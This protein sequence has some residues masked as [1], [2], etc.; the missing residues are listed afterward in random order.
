MSYLHV[1]LPTCH[2][3]CTK[4][5]FFSVTI[6]TG[7][8]FF[9]GFG[10]T[11]Y[12]M[13]SVMTYVHVC[14]GILMVWNCKLHE[15]NTQNSSCDSTD[16]QW[17]IVTAYGTRCVIKVKVSLKH[18]GLKNVWGTLFVPPYALKLSQLSSA[19]HFMSKSCSIIVW[20]RDAPWSSKLIKKDWLSHIC[21]RLGKFNKTL[22][23]LC[24]WERENGQC[25]QDCSCVHC[26]LL[27]YLR[28]FNCVICL[29]LDISECSG[30]NMMRVS[31]GVVYLWSHSLW[32][33]KDGGGE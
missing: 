31:C 25:S 11:P 19:Q 9:G 6:F 13:C 3:S 24:I 4:N 5:D 29:F 12:T 22:F 28:L 26:V 8:V 16:P 23:F 32:G 10:I 27:L 18:K 2:W 30:D 33:K 7:K 17:K 1:S 15:K 20:W 14:Y 21:W